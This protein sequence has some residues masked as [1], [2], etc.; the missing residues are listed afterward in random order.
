MIPNSCLWINENC[1]FHGLY[2]SNQVCEN[3]CK[4]KY[5]YEIYCVYDSSFKINDCVYLWDSINKQKI[6]DRN[7]V[8]QYPNDIYLESSIAKIYQSYRLW[9]LRLKIVGLGQL[10]TTKDS[11]L[12]ETGIVWR[13]Q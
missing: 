5:L 2:S 8:A 13:K 3:S 9:L 1:K 12:S 10:I 6:C 11:P 4:I 7:S